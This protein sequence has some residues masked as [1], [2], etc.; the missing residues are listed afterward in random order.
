MAPVG[1]DGGAGNPGGDMLD[2]LLEEWER[3][4]G[5]T[6]SPSEPIKL[7]Q[8]SSRTGPALGT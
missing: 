6:S 4:K 1:G 7:W 5:L 8:T 2:E 3:H